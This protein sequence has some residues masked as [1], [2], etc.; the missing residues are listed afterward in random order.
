MSLHVGPHGKILNVHLQHEC[1]DASQ[2]PKDSGSSSWRP[3]CLMG[4]GP[5]CSLLANVLIIWNLLEP[6]CRLMEAGHPQSD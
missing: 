4:Q 2:S 1:R 6:W 3:V 5:D